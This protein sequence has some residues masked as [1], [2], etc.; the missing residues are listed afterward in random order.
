LIVT[1]LRQSGQEL[2]G[3]RVEKV[4]KER[5]CL[6]IFIFLPRAQARPE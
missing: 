1:R 4:E 3:K 6:E 5:K 2:E